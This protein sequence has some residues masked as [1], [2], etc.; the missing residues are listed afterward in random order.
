MLLLLDITYENFTR[1]P[2]LESLD[3]AAAFCF[4]VRAR[5]QK[6]RRILSTQQN[7]KGR[8]NEKILK[9]QNSE[10]A[11]TCVVCIEST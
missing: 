11:N 10:Q 4:S 5:Y 2:A 6:R 1:Y 7:Q 8:T 9:V 3:L